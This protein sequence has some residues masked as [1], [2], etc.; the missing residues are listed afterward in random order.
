MLGDLWDS[1]VSSRWRPELMVLGCPSCH[2]CWFFVV[3]AFLLLLGYLWW[4][5]PSSWLSES[6]SAHHTL[7]A[8]VQLFCFFF[9]YLPLG[10]SDGV[11]VWPLAAY[12]RLPGIY[13]LWLTPSVVNLVTM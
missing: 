12:L 3:I 1:V 7:Y 8:V 5:L 9:L 11:P 13:S 4:V 10:M 6:H 2:L